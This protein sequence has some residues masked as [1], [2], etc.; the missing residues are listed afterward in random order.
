MQSESLP[1]PEVEF[2]EFT[3][4]DQWKQKLFAAVHNPALAESHIGRRAVKFD[5]RNAAQLNSQQL[6][7]QLRHNSFV[8]PHGRDCV[9]YDYDGAQ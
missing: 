1:L 6:G 3:G 7:R 4:T 9:V 8:M 2:I 5:G